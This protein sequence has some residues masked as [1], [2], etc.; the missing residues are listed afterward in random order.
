M[1]E[2]VQSRAIPMAQGAPALPVAWNRVMPL[3][4]VAPLLVYMVVFY[5]LPVI[6]MLLRSV[7][8]PTWTLA[9]YAA[10][11]R[12]TVFLNT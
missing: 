2:T 9:N 6:S 7:S 12:D 4:L 11:P 3:L 5:A 1:S 10:L 8:E